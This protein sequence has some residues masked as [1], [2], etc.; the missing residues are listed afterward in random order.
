MDRINK[1]LADLT[2]RK[3]NGNQ[4]EVARA[5]DVKPQTFGN[6]LKGRKLPIS[7]VDK[8]KEVYGE[9]LLELS[10]K[11]VSTTVDNVNVSEPEV[12]FRHM[13]T[14]GDYVGLHKKAW[15]EFQKTL[16]HNRKVITEITSTNSELGKGILEIIGHLTKVTGDQHS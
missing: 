7:L 6:Y 14:E 15:E 8:W 13:I 3:G 16:E 1:I 5:L 10:K 12:P 9:D 2:L 11:D 4:A